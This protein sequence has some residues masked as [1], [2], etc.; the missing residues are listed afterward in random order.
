MIGPRNAMDGDI[1]AIQR[2]TADPQLESKLEDC[3]E[4]ISAVRAVHLR[5]AMELAGQV[6]ERTREWLEVT[7]DANEL[8]E[9]EERLVVATVESIDPEPVMVRR[10]VINRLREDR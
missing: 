7:T 1:E 6:L 4:A 9:V 3:I 2:A 5:V 8:M 10:G